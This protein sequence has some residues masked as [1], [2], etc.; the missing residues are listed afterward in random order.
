MTTSHL[1]FPYKVIHHTWC[2]TGTSSGVQ[3]DLGN[4]SGQPGNRWNW[5]PFLPLFYKVLKYIQT[6][7]G[8]LFGISEPSTV[9]GLLKWFH[10]VHGWLGHQLLYSL[11]FGMAYIFR[12]DSWW[13]FVLGRVS[14]GHDLV[15]AKYIHLRSIPKIRPQ[16]DLPGM[17]QKPCSS[18]DMLGWSK[19][20]LSWNMNLYHITCCRTLVTNVNCEDTRSIIRRTNTV[21][22]P[23][24]NLHQSHL[25]SWLGRMNFCTTHNLGD[26]F[27]PVENKL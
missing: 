8:W 7:V 3:V 23:D 24:I 19:H 10:N 14:L 13:L 22:S 9:P 26:G 5:D 21:M 16:H 15:V 17:N 6:L 2:H 20:Y 11:L 27:N 1:A 4:C 25:R 12:C 18:W